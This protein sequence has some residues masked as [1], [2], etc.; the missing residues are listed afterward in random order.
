MLMSLKDQAIS[1]CELFI[2]LG[3]MFRASPFRRV[4][5]VC[6]K[7]N[8]SVSWVNEQQMIGFSIKA[9]LHMLEWRLNTESSSKTINKIIKS[10]YQKKKK[11]MVSFL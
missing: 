8:K 1:L 9:S 11:I 5:A 3:C 6:S 7:S 10:V 2:Y 4:S